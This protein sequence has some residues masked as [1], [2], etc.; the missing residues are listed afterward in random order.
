LMPTIAPAR[1]RI[2]S[3][4]RDTFLNIKELVPAGHGRDIQI[5]VG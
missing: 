1:S 2:P 5:A 4:V 3:A